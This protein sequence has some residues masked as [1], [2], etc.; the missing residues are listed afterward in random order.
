MSDYEAVSA[1]RDEAITSLSIVQQLLELVVSDNPPPGIM[2]EIR[3][4]ITKTE[5]KSR[6]AAYS[7]ITS[8]KQRW[9]EIPTPVSELVLW[10]ST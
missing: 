3:S 5:G 8:N 10:L 2:D 1:E 4:V 6:N 7:N 9:S